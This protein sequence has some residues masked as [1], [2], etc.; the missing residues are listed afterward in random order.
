M[1]Y[2]EVT[3]SD[4]FDPTVTYTYYVSDQFP[5][6][7]GVLIALNKLLSSSFG[8]AFLRPSS[9]LGSTEYYLEYTGEPDSYYRVRNDINVEF[10]NLGSELFHG[11]GD[12]DFFG[13]DGNYSQ[14]TLERV[15]TH[16]LVHYAMGLLDPP[17]IYG[18]PTDR[19]DPNFQQDFIDKYLEFNE[20]ADA[21]V[22]GPT[23]D[24][25]NQIMESFY[26]GTADFRTHYFGFTPDS[27]SNAQPKPDVAKYLSEDDSIKRTKF[28]LE[29]YADE[30]TI[31]SDSTGMLVDYSDLLIGFDGSETLISG[32]GRDFLFGGIGDDF[33][34]GGTGRDVLVGGEGEDILD[35]SAELDREQG[36]E[37]FDRDIWED[38]LHFDDGESDLLEGGAGDDTYLIRI[39][40]SVDAAFEQNSI[41]QH[42]TGSFGSFFDVVIYENGQS[43]QLFTKAIDV[44]AY[45]HIDR[46]S[47][48][49][50][51][52]TI[53]VDNSSW[54][55]V[56]ELS[57]H[58][59]LDLPLEFSNG[60][61]IKA[62][63]SANIYFLEG[64][65]GF[66]GNSEGFVYYEGG[67]LY[68]FTTFDKF[69]EKYFEIGPGVEGSLVGFHARFVIENFQPGQFGINIDVPDEGS[70][71]DD[72]EDFS[73]GS[74]STGANYAAL[75]GND[76]VVGTDL[77]DTLS[78]G[79]GNDDLSG[80][81]DDDSLSGES[82]NDVIDGG[83]GNDFVDGGSG[84]DDLTGG[85]GDDAVYGKSGNDDLFGGSG[86]DYISGG[87]G[88]D[89][90]HGGFDD[91]VLLGNKGAD[92]LSDLGGSDTYEYVAGDGNDQISDSGLASETDRL[93]L[94]DI[95]SDDL[96][97]NRVGAGQQDLRIL[98]VST[99]EAIIVTNQFAADAG[100]GTN[101]GIE[102][103][104]IQSSG[105]DDDITYTAADIE[106][107]AMVSGNNCSCRCQR[108]C[109]S[110]QPRRRCL[111]LYGSGWHVLGR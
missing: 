82:G 4:P 42:Y 45:D 76:T 92:V 56:V 41:Y 11:G 48:S 79:S 97:L 17:Q 43:A 16:E 110:V 61:Y 89:N 39:D 50:G 104:V 87:D 93:I 25:T 52:G 65:G 19:S 53:L 49:D 13:D 12:L 74:P 105:Q 88:Q 51:N 5:D 66:A 28:A 20:N 14:F 21:N 80:G 67:N 57:T 71:G 78:G 22:T 10:V 26:P 24:L 103:L 64:D 91:D 29:G 69:G 40:E 111:E 36:L 108:P 58:A 73:Q 101:Q 77:K 38:R 8:S 83:E 85:A 107:A 7:D 96:V 68:G 94:K 1:P 32:G 30:E 60:N 55:Y 23:V 15:L 9:G 90:L 100:D 47:D 3:K 63:G 35:G 98:I 2:K 37:Q 106:A 18:F 70:E 95:S 72:N 33:L 81:M 54:G 109:R 75:G 44:D 27:N 34:F 6:V 102:Q 46:I 86:R 84:S 62:K 31:R 59:T 99:G